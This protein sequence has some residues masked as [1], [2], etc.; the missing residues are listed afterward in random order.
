MPF[1]GS[2]LIDENLPYDLEC[3][4]AEKNVPVE[5]I[6]KIGKAGIKNGEVYQYAEINKR[7]I[8]TRDVDFQNYFKFQQY[9]IGGIIL[10]KTSLTNKRYL[11]KF[12]NK[13]WNEHSNKLN[14]KL[15][16]IIEDSKV[17]FLE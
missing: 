10:I 3:F 12:L 4:F 11:L 5:H 14:K 17:T 9:N 15:L 6:K 1:K 13:F 16:V 8:I 2:I 7:W